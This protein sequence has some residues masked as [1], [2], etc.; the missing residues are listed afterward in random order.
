[1]VDEGAG[2]FTYAPGTHRK[3]PVRQ[4]PDYFVDE[5]GAWRSTDEQMAVVLPPANWFNAVGP[6]GTIIFADTR[7]YHKGGLARSRDRLMYLCMFT[8]RAAVLKGMWGQHLGC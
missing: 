2:P 3:G 7:G 4:R 8:S 6:L 5:K 1:D